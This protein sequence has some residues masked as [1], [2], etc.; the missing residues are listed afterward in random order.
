MALG[1]ILALA[2]TLLSQPAALEPTSAR[3]HD[4]FPPGMLPDELK[5]LYAEPLIA[6]GEPP[7]AALAGEEVYRF[8]SIGI[9]GGAPAHMIRVTR[10]GKVVRYRAA[11]FASGSWRLRD[12]EPDLD[13]WEIFH[14]GHLLEDRSGTMSD[15]DWQLL[16]STLTS[17]GFWTL[18]T[19]EP[20]PTRPQRVFVLHGDDWVIEGRGLDGYHLVHRYSP[21]STRFPAVRILGEFLR[22]ISRP[23]D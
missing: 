2:G 5:R 9:Q 14:R 8:L 13:R 20:A 19:P 23:S 21:R 1:T 15:S 7:L 6:L 4:Y 12:T 11:S 17:T 22:W 3:Y 16:R 18:S 10:M